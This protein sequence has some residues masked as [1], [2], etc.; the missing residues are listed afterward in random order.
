MTP[1]T[2]VLSVGILALVV[3]IGHLT[4][5]PKIADLDGFYHIG[6]AFAYAEGSMFNTSMPWATQSIIA[7]QGADLWWGFHVALMPFTLIGNVDWAIR[8]AAIALTASLALCFLWILGRHGVTGAGWWTALFLIAVPDVFFRHLMLRPHI[9]SVA[10]SLALLSFMTR[11][12]WRLVFMASALIAWLH[13]GV[14]WMAPAVAIAYGLVRLGEALFGL[15]PGRESVSPSVAIS[16]SFLGTVAGW[17]LRPHPIEAGV[18]ANVQILRLFA[19]KATEAPLLFAADL[20]PMPF[21]ELV[22]TSWFFLTAWLIVAIGTLTYLGRDK[23]SNIPREERTLLLTTLVISLAFALI[24]TLSAR[25]AIEQ[26]VAFGALA[27]PVFWTHVVYVYHRRS[28]RRFVLLALSLHLG[29]GAWRHSLNVK[30]AA[31]EPDTMESAARFLADNSEPGQVVFHTRLDNFGPLFAFNRDNLYIGG[32]DPIFQFVHEPRFYWEY[33]YVS[34]DINV[35][36]T[37][38]AFP[39][40]RGNMT[41]MYTVLRDHFAARWVV[42]EP[43]RNPR[44]SLYLSNDERYRLAHES[45]SEAVFEVV[46][47]LSAAPAFD[48]ILGPRRIN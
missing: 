30:H 1:R 3:V 20:F 37:C 44:F 15:K 7:D 35:E 45:P 4:L 27:L 38:D 29:W 14:F 23:L 12:R 41:D 48:S 39:C 2:S 28:V 16:A 6:H 40:S 22:S 8:V 26:W 47:A 43:S 5:F 32:M 9:L 36:S 13:L 34:S 11:G 42:V 18:L 10:A 33:F 21:L 19:Q 31:F 17:L 24:A 46:G 25:G